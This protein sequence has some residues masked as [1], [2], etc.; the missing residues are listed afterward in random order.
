MSAK[1]FDPHGQ[2]QHGGGDGLQHI[3]GPCLHVQEA[4]EMQLRMAGDSV[5]PMLRVIRQPDQRAGIEREAVVSWTIE[6]VDRP[7][8]RPCPIEQQQKTMQQHI[9]KP[10]EGRVAV[11]QSPLAREIRQMQR[12]RTVRPE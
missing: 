9:E 11:M 1:R 2:T 5:A 7:S 12:Q 3:G 6:P 10:R 8:L 4:R